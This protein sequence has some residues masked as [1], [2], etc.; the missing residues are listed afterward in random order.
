M[1]QKIVIAG[2]RVHGV[3]YRPFLIAL[4]DEFEIGT[5][6]VHNSEEDGKLIVIAKADAED[7]QLGAFIDAERARKPKK[8]DV[9]GIRCEPFEGRVPSIVRTSILCM[10][11]QLC[12]CIDKLECINEMMDLRL[13]HEDKNQNYGR[14]GAWS[15]LSAVAY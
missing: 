2:P 8:A 1:K 13:K 12:S 10:N 11:Y 14:Q 6:S 7:A 15:R 5:F 9:S 3:G 4:S